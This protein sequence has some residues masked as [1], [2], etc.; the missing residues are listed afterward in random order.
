VIQLRGSLR[1]S[2]KARTH[3]FA[4]CQIGREYFDGHEAPQLEVACA[5]HGRH[6]SAADFRFDL[7]RVADCGNHTLAQL[8]RHNVRA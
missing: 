2:Q 3:L 7:I 1:L 5:V 8:I 6:A 4:K